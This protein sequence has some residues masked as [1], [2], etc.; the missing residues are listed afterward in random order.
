MIDYEDNLEDSVWCVDRRYSDFNNSGWNKDVASN[1]AESYYFDIDKRFAYNSTLD[2]DL[3]CDVA[4][5]YTV[6]N[7]NGNGKFDYMTGLLTLDE[8]ALGGVMGTRSTYLHSGVEY[9]SMS[10]AP[11][12]SSTSAYFVSTSGGLLHTSVNDPTLY[13]RPAVS[14]RNDILYSTGDGSSDNPFVI[15]ER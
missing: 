12:L 9:W 14:L 1:I 2:I 5:S 13:A 6:K 3:T 8:L 15:I 11:I 4:D 10:P 7:T